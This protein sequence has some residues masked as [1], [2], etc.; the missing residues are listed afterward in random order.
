MKAWEKARAGIENVLETVEVLTRGIDRYD[1]MMLAA[2][3]ILTVF[4]IGFFP[5]KW[6]FLFCICGLMTPVACNALRQN[7]NGQT[8]VTGLVLQT[9]NLVLV[10]V[11]LFQ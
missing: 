4:G 7:K 11:M 5:Q 10:G 1:A 9:I 8:L 2:T 6:S 3:V